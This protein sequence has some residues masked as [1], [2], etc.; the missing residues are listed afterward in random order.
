MLFADELKSQA[1]INHRG[2]P[3]TAAPWAPGALAKSTGARECPRSVSWGSR[4]SG[5]GLIAEALPGPA[6]SAECL[7]TAWLRAESSEGPGVQLRGHQSLG[8]RS[9]S[10][11]LNG[12][13]VLSAKSC[14]GKCTEG[15]SQAEGASGA[16]FCLTD[17]NPVIK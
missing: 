6:A 5:L 17:D 3:S 14:P 11:G 1:S 15:L 4:A 16:D 12:L 2:A 13:G 7:S 10:Y 8:A 9:V